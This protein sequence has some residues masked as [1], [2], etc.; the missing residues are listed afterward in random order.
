MGTFGGCFSRYKLLSFLITLASSF[1]LL[2]LSAPAQTVTRAYAGDDGKAHIEFADGK[3]R[4]MVREEQQVGVDEV[5]IASDER[6]VAWAVLYDNCCTSYPIR[7]ALV[8]FRNDKK[9]VLPVPQMIHDWRFVGHGE[10]VALLY[11]PVHGN[12]SGANL[13][14]AGNGKLVES[15]HGKEPGPT[16]AEEWSGAFA[17]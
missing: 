14:D 6:T 9:F 15:W 4:T 3:S 11:G 12:A 8:I 13:Y 17:P 2:N 5:T 10:R 1:L 7:G 16:W